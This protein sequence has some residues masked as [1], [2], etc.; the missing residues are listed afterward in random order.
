MK[1]QM[2]AAAG[3]ALAPLAVAIPY[4]Q[5]HVRHAHLHHQEKRDVQT[6]VDWEY[7]TEVVTVTAGAAQQQWE[8]HG[9]PWHKKSSSASSEAAPSTTSAAVP[10]TT[11]TTSVAS[12]ST[13]AALPTSSEVES[14]TSI[15]A[16]SPSSSSSSPSSTW[17]AT[18]SSS[19]ADPTYAVTT[20]SSAAA[21]SSSSSTAE[22]KEPASS[23][24]S[25]PSSYS[26]GITKSNLT[27]NGRKAGL[28][29][30]I[31]IQEKNAFS[32]LAPHISWYSDY[33]PNTP[34]SNGVKGIGMLWG[35]DGSTC[36][37]TPER[38]SI[39]NRLA[40]DDVVPE[41][42]FGFYEPDCSCDMSSDMSTS[43]GTAQWNSLLAPMAKKGTVLGS[44]SMCHQRD[45]IWLQPF[46]DGG[47]DADWDVTSVHINKPNIT[48]VK[49]DIEYYLS[50]YKKPI[51]VSE[52]ACVD[53]KNGF[54]A[55]T[56]QDQINTFISDAVNFF[57]GNDSVVAFGPSNGAHL[58]TVWPLTKDGELTASGKAYRD[59]IKDL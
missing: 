24:S 16:S 51:W 3:A 32:D 42:M 11:L 10:A 28:S 45:E 6:K 25:S 57:Q 34:D 40:T 54:V 52:F 47:L 38:L 58:G 49:E 43:A 23:T 14:T 46:I 13:E 36:G 8:N 50:T 27:P 4:Q 22:V 12:S 30:Y 41:I 1:Y 48:G 2:V 59:A 21:P 44:P 55:C 56:D 26:T 17:S 20:S 35:A 19:T 18:S 15:A 37:V 5:P 7:V 31:G 53:D 39:F 33:T 9:H 29:G